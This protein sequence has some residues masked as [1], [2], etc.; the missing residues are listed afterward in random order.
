[1]YN[2]TQLRFGLQYCIEKMPFLQ[3]NLNFGFFD[4]MCIAQVFIFSLGK[5]H[6]QR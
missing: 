1:M 5:F 2:T 4:I 6:I 3:I